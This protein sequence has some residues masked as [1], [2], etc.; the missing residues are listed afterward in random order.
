MSACA[1]GFPERDGIFPRVG[2][3]W[4][5]GDPASMDALR[6]AGL[7]RAHAVII[8]DGALAFLQRASHPLSWARCLVLIMC[9]LCALSPSV[10]SCH[11]GRVC[12]HSS[13]LEHFPRAGKCDN[14]HVC[15]GYS[16]VGEVVS[17][18]QLCCGA[19][20]NAPAKEADAFTLTILTLAQV[21]N[22]APRGC[23]MP[24]VS[25]GEAAPN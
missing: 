2:F 1:Q 18:M 11:L 7:E 3:R 19:G 22:P 17:E 10:H 9:R 6:R 12:L 24:L 16:H 23:C 25:T 20:S 15:S 5:Q 14:M 4:V 21:I 13:Q 8:G